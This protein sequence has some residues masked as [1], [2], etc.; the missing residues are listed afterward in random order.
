MI[1]YY[2][3]LWLNNIVFTYLVQDFSHELALATSSLDSFSPF[4]SA[5]LVQQVLYNFLTVTFILEFFRL[6]PFL[7]DLACD[8]VFFCSRFDV[9]FQLT[10]G[11]YEV[12]GLNSWRPYHSL[13]RGGCILGGGIATIAQ[14]TQNG[15]KTILLVGG[16]LYKIIRC[17]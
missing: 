5:S 1:F 4:L 11:L 12:E 6:C 9:S 13:N 17:Q 15:S 7:S 16:I 10:E 3:I 2:N 8:M 14:R